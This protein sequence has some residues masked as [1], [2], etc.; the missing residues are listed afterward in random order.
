MKIVNMSREV[1]RLRLEKKRL[2]SIE[3]LVREFFPSCNIFRTE[4]SISIDALSKE[5]I[6]DFTTLTYAPGAMR[7]YIKDYE[8]KAINFG[9]EYEKR[10]LHKSP[11]SSFD[12]PFSLEKHYLS[13]D[14]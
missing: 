3:H 9:G 6:A 1:R 7:L 10:G 8:E 12:G 2:D 5:R 11:E 14:F 4:V 13:C